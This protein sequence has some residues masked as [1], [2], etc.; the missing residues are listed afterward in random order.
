MAVIDIIKIVIKMKGKIDLCD[1]KGLEYE[2]DNNKRVGLLQ[3]YASCMA[4]WILYMAVPVLY[5]SVCLLWLCVSFMNLCT[6]YD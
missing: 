2:N 4:I 3:L 1:E 5:G 6:S